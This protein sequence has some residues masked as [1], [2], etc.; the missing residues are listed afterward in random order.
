LVFRAE[1]LILHGYK[2]CIK[3]MDLFGSRPH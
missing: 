3:N 2:F 1:Q